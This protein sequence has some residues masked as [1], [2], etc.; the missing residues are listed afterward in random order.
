MYMVGG[1]S[2]SDWE[3]L[4]RSASQGFAHAQY[5]V[6]THHQNG[7]IPFTKD[8]VRAYLWHSLAAAQEHAT[9]EQRRTEL[10]KRMSPQQIAEAERRAK[11]WKAGQCAGRSWE[12]EERTAT[13]RPPAETPPLC[14][15][16]GGY[17]AY[18]KRTGKVCRLD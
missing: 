7:D 14:H 13:M 4:C 2:A 16:V 6:G 3:W 17:E 10:A 12:A 1:Y 11:T 15:D 8:S 9:A 18:M 5:F